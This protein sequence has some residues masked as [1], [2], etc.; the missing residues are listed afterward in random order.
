MEAMHLGIY[1]EEDENWEVYLVWL[2]FQYQGYG[3]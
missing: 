1:K 2:I 3:T